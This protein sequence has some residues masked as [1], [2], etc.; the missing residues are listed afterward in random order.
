VP[1]CTEKGP[2]KPFPAAEIQDPEEQPDGQQDQ[3]AVEDGDV[4]V[5][6]AEGRGDVAFRK[7]TG[8]GFRNDQIV[9]AELAQPEVVRLTDG[10]TAMKRSTFTQNIFVGFPIL[11]SN[12]LPNQ[13]LCTLVVYR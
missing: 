3:G 6:R 7:R 5:D 10:I 2:E 9:D 8:A 12:F 1:P 11:V 4:G 13:R